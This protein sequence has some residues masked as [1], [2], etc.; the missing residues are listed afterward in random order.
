MPAHLMRDNEGALVIEYALIL[1][2]ISVGLVLGLQPLVIGSNFS[3]F[4]TR[5]AACLTGTCV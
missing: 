1:A 2:L 4:I 3:S 5:F